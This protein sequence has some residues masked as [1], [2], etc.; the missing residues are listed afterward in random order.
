ML[1]LHGGDPS[2]HEEPDLPDGGSDGRGSSDG[3]IP[4]DLAELPEDPVL[5]L[6]RAIHALAHLSQCSGDSAPKTKVHKPDTFDSSD[7]KKLCEFLVQCKLNFQHH[8]K[9]FRTNRAKV[10]FAQ[11]YLKGMVL[12]WFKPDLLNPD[13]YFHCPL[14]MDNYREFLHKLTTN[15]GLHDAVTDTVQNLENLSV[16]DSSHIPNL[17]DCIKDKISHVGKP[18]TLIGLC[19]LAQTIDVQYWGHK[20]KISHTAKP[21]ADKSSSTKSSNDKKSSN[22]PIHSPLQCQGQVQV[23]GQPKA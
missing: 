9:A 20:A 8:P 10:T 6:T 19:E 14:W 22:F 4:E 1:P 5:A 16:K 11:S 2:N 13:D 23:E 3:G 7:L 12:A 15:F 18:A 21:S 17:P